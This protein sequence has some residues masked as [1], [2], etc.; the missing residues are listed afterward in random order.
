MTVGSASRTV[1]SLASPPPSTSSTRPTRSATTSALR[2]SDPRIRKHFI[3][4]SKVVA[5]VAG[6]VV[7]Y[8]ALSPAYDAVKLARWTSVKDY[9]DDCR[10]HNSSSGLLSA[11]CQEV[12]R[13]PM[14]PP[15]FF[16]TDSAARSFSKREMNRPKMIDWP[17]AR[18]LFWALLP[19]FVVPVFPL[20]GVVVVFITIEYGVY[21][22]ARH[23]L[24]CFRRR[25]GLRH[26]R[27]ALT[28]IPSSHVDSHELPD[29]WVATS[30]ARLAALTSPLS[31]SSALRLRH[32]GHSWEAVAV[33]EED[34]DCDQWM[35]ANASSVALCHES[36]NRPGPMPSQEQGMVCKLFADG[37]LAEDHADKDEAAPLEADKPHQATTQ[38]VKSARRHRRQIREQAKAHSSTIGT[39]LG[40]SPTELEIL[41]EQA[42]LLE[43]KPHVSGNRVIVTSLSLTE[44]ATELDSAMTSMTVRI[45]KVSADCRATSTSNGPIARRSHPCNGESH[46]PLF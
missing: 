2:A 18:N 40:L 9:R 36:P 11:D 45:E 30:T 29:A 35:P 13:H 12:L 41:G 6:L 38:A 26:Q 17:S 14:S 42:L 3:V 39:Q 25:L 24:D 1:G 34:S 23:R 19:L 7:A 15:P 5:V 8:V 46:Q 44:L 10:S 33:A 4:C 27:A 20:V 28:P 32:S 43:Q 37:R 21:E 16:S 22:A 31:T